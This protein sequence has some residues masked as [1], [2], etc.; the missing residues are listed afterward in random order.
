MDAL[1]LYGT[2]NGG[3]VLGVGPAL[4]NAGNAGLSGASAAAALVAHKERLRAQMQAEAL[5]PLGADGNDD[6]EQQKRLKKAVSAID[7]WEPD[8][9][10]EATQF[11]RL[12]VGLSHASLLLFCR[13]RKG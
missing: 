13:L 3:P 5:T 8:M 6:D 10:E 4:G 1:A 12:Q 2:T 11:L 9:L 7:Q